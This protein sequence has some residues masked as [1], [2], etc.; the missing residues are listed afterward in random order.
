M[1]C[2]PASPNPK[3]GVLLIILNGLISAPVTISS[4]TSRQYKVFV[5]FHIGKK[6]EEIA[7]K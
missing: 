7:G 4:T 6:R 3:E 1:V 2:D 5:I